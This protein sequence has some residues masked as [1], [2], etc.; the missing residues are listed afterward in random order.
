[1]YAKAR[2]SGGPSMFAESLRN[3]L[4]AANSVD[5]CRAGGWLALVTSV[6]GDV[7]GTG[8]MGWAW[9]QGAGDAEQFLF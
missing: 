2:D 9:A 1:M 4:S 5:Y 3:F 7:V 6:R 8:G